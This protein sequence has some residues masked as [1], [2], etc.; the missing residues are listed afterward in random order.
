[1]GV[2][3]TFIGN[4]KGPRGEQG[5]QG[6]QGVEGLQGPRGEQG[7]QGEPGEVGPQGPQGVP[8]PQGEP[9][10]EGPQG[11]QGPQGEPGAAGR[12]IQSTVL[13]EDYTLTITF[14]DGSSYTTP[15]IRGAD[16]PP[17]E[18]AKAHIQDMENPH[19]VTPEQIGA[20]KA[21]QLGSM[22]YENVIIHN[23]ATELP[24]VVEGA[25]LITYDEE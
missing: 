21:E 24:E 7:P 18:S 19:G 15:S 16:G 5:P 10:P 13:N 20:V 23:S 3:K 12:G 6:L 14:D 9:G 8:G 22:A 2:I 25:I 11:I 17:D 1:M 4:I